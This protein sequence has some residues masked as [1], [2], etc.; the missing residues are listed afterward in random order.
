MAYAFV[1]CDEDGKG[2]WIRQPVWSEFGK[3]LAYEVVSDSKVLLAG[4]DGYLILVLARVVEIMAKAKAAHEPG[5]RATGVPVTI[6]TA[7]HND[8]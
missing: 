6:D 7:V 2:S 5:E 3:E 8:T 1:I 4:N